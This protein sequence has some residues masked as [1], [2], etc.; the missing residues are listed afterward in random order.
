MTRAYLYQLVQSSGLHK[1]NIA[2]HPII[3]IG[4]AN[5]SAKAGSY[6]MNNHKVRAK[7][8]TEATHIGHH[9]RR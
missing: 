7:T 4:T 1:N 9:A 6:G 2:T 8:K 5:I 3:A